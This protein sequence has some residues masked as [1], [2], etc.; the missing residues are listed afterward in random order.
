M[1]FTRLNECYL[2][3]GS[4]AVG[5]GVTYVNTVEQH[6]DITQGVCEQVLYFIYKFVFKY[7]VL[8]VV[9]IKIF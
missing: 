3:S 8:P 5:C 9:I 6:Y 2:P 1:I 4:I 7:P